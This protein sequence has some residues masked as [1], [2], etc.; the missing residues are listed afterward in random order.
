M[1][2]TSNK[3][4]AH[5]REVYLLIENE[6]GDTVVNLDAEQARNPVG[7]LCSYAERVNLVIKK[8]RS[9]RMAALITLNIMSYEKYYYFTTSIANKFQKTKATLSSKPLGY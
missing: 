9:S 2:V 7:V 3:G 6:D 8:R 5:Y 1:T 4:E